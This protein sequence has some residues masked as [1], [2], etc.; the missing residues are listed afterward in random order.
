MT[1]AIVVTL[2]RVAVTRR[3]MLEWQ[4]AATSRQLTDPAA[5]AGVRLFVEQMVASPL[6]AVAALWS[7]SAM[8]RPRALPAALPILLLWMAAPFVA[9]AL[10]PAGRRADAPG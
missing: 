8:L 9:Y 4:T 3:K 1:H 10:Q 5:R 7:R 6:F 2:V